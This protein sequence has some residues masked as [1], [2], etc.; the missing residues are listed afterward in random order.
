[1]DYSCIR[2]NKPKYSDIPA[3]FKDYEVFNNAPPRLEDHRT[4]S[5]KWME[6]KKTFI[7]WIWNAQ[8]MMKDPKDPLGRR[9]N[10][11]NFRQKMRVL[12]HYM[13]YMDTKHKYKH[14]LP[15]MIKAEAIGNEKYTYAPNNNS[16]LHS[17]GTEC[18]SSQ[19]QL[20][21]DKRFCKGSQGSFPSKPD[22]IKLYTTKR[23]IVHRK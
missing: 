22:D 6:D 16:L 1:M 23:G 13:Q 17:L 8:R 19:L 9:I 11:Q 21:F 12:L 2:R 20:I 18:T 7:A 10:D 3:A 4:S 15:G 5:S 14:E